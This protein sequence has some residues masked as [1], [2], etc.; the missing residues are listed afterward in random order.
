MAPGRHTC[1]QI[2]R[3]SSSSRQRSLCASRSQ[4]VGLAIG[5]HRLYLQT[6]IQKFVRASTRCATGTKLNMYKVKKVIKSTH[7]NQQGALFAF[8]CNSRINVQALQDGLSLDSSGYVDFIR[9]SGDKWRTLR[10]NPVRLSEL[11]W[12]YDNARCNV[13]KESKVFM[14]KRGLSWLKQSP[15][16]PDLN[17]CDHCYFTS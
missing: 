5:R 3:N 2:D 6:T 9:Q 17:I 12:H 15:Y 13:S 16:S 14:A 4:Q 7:F 8:S 11:T 10:S 1:L